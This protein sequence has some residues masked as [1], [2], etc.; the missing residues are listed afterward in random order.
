MVGVPVG[1][2]SVPEPTAAL[3]RRHVVRAI[4]AELV[5]PALAGVALGD[6]V[7]ESSMRRRPFSP[8][9]F[10]RDG[11]PPLG[12]FVA[13]ALGALFDEPGIARVRA[14]LSRLAA[15]ADVPFA[16]LAGQA[17]GAWFEDASRPVVARA[18]ARV[19]PSA[20]P[21][22]ELIR[23]WLA[24]EPPARVTRPRVRLLPS[25][26][27]PLAGL[28]SSWFGGLDV[29]PALVLRPS[30]PRLVAA[31]AVPLA[32]AAAS[33]VADTSAA[34]VLARRRVQ[35]RG[36]ETPLA[37][38]FVPPLLPWFDEPTIARRTRRAYAL[39]VTSEGLFVV[40]QYV[41]APP[42]QRAMLLASS[43][44]GKL[45]QASPQRGVLLRGGR[46]GVLR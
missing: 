31:D 37:A 40:V 2:V 19:T 24:E 34:R 1:E 36:T 45:L 30:R 28:I 38:F 20:D 3:V 41:P 9:P 4:G 5:P 8:V 43:T 21:L 44:H 17:L 39:F 14:T 26:E 46:S 15:G 25:V 13:P 23:P 42:G 18:R 32:S 33:W 35:A 22:L 29:A 10:V 6:F 11:A 27:T 12:A 16:A 7:H